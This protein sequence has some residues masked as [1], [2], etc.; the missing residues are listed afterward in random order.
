M[1][2]WPRD[3]RVDECGMV[4]TENQPRGK[5]SIGENVNKLGGS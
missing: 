5:V 2:R 4:R 1:K 3:G